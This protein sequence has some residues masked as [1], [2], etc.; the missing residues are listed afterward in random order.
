M[1]NPHTMA[2]NLRYPG[3]PRLADKLRMPRIQPQSSCTYTTLDVPL[4]GAPPARSAATSAI[5]LDSLPASSESLRP[6]ADMDNGNLQHSL[7]QKCR[8]MPDAEIAQWVRAQPKADGDDLGG[9]T[10]E[11]PAEV[12]RDLPSE[13]A[14]DAE[15][16]DWFR[17]QEARK[18]VD[19]TKEAG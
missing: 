9:L 3:R 12:R 13:S 4:N 7:M 11:T 17:A 15:I 6:P 1:L 19:V 14:S 16:V 2:Q 18:E 8:A 5:N 10:Q